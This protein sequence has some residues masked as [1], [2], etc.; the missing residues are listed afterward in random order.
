MTWA[1]RV[2]EVH[3]RS[4]HRSLRGFARAVGLSRETIRRWESADYEPLLS[5]AWA[6]ADAVGWPIDQ[7]VGDEPLIGPPAPLVKTTNPFKGTAFAASL[8][9]LAMAQ[10]SSMRGVSVASGVPSGTVLG[11]TNYRSEPT[12]CRAKLVANALGST[13][14]AM[15]LGELSGSASG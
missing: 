11:W 8:V 13:L 1:S 3:E 12:I 6:F 10:Q 4:G 5:W 15:V 14:H 9:R 2:A 7:L